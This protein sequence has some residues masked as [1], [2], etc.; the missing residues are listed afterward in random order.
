MV[1]LSRSPPVRSEKAGVRPRSV[2]AAAASSGAD[3]YDEEGDCGPLEDEYGEDLRGAGTPAAKH[4][5]LAT[6]VLDG[7]AGQGGHVVEDHYCDEDQHHEH[8][9]PGE[10]YA[11]LVLGENGLDSRS[12]TV[13]GER[14]GQHAVH[15]PH[16]SQSW[17]GIS[18]VHA[19]H[20]QGRGAR[21]RCPPFS[22]TT[23]R[24]PP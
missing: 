5:H 21:R 8:R 18:S 1:T 12:M 11:P 14:R 16:S 7:Q 24:A 4:G 23:V 22:G 2:M 6:A 13:G 19:V 17:F 3:E 10:E 20:V 9:H 15:C